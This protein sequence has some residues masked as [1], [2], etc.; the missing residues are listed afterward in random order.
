MKNDNFLKY[1]P[2]FI[3][4]AFW[5]VTYL[6]YESRIFIDYPDRNSGL[7]FIFFM[8][9]LTAGLVGYIAASLLKI[10]Y[11]SKSSYRRQALFGFYFYA[12]LFYPAVKIYTGNN[13][14]DFFAL[15]ASPLEAYSNM[16]EQL[17]QDRM[18]R[19]WLI[20]SK[21]IASPFILI[22]L[23]Y[24]FMRVIV[25]GKDKTHLAIMVLLYFAMSV[26][27]GTDKQLFDVFIIF[28]TTFLAVK[29]RFIYKV[30]STKKNISQFLCLVFFLIFIIGAFS[31][32]KE[33]RLQSV[34]QR[35]L[36][37]QNVCYELK[38][39][40][41]ILFAGTL[42]YTY[43]TQGYYGLSVSFDAEFNSS[44]GFGHSSSLEYLGSLL[45]LSFEKNVVDQLDELG[46]AAKGRWS[47]GF[48][49]IANDIP[50]YFIPFVSFFLFFFMSISY[51]IYRESKDVL[52]LTIFVYF[53]YTLIYMPANLQIAQSGDLY[54]GF[55]LLTLLFL[56][57]IFRA[58]V[59]V[60][61]I[62]NPS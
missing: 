43:L 3:P 24:F 20:I 6:A 46:W 54:L 12:L 8:A 7:L 60:T 62:G 55:L 41:N 35:C 52:A 33:D 50:F 30:F 15:L 26:F 32:K 39:D 56:L 17:T 44:Y 40:N 58:N 53:M 11:F 37:S 42:L 18:D 45:G 10:S 21:I 2:V 47:T 13:I 16:Q 48:V 57:K 61:E 19:I 51:K 34:E 25:Y 22:A 4:L 59:S 38:K 27:R 36:I 9:N 23:P 29:P 1:Q 5:L 49:S 28:F 31:L 14:L